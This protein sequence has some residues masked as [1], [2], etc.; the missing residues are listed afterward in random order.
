MIN[1]LKKLK[2]NARKVIYQFYPLLACKQRYYWTYGEKI[3]LDNPR[4]VDEKNIWL[5][6]NR[7]KNDQRIIDLI[8]KAK[9]YEV[10]GKDEKARQYLNV[11][12]KVYDKA[13]D[14]EWDKLP[15]KFAVKCNH[16]CGMNIFITDKNSVDREA[17]VKKLDRWMKEKQLMEFGGVQYKTIKPKIV[18]ERFL[19][20][21]DGKPPVDYKL[22]CCNGH[23]EAVEVIVDR[24]ENYH[25]VLVDR[26]FKNLPF[27]KDSINDENVI[28]GLKPKKWPD[29]VEAA[30]YLSHKYPYVRVDLYDYEDRPL[31]GEMTFFPMDGVNGFFEM[32][33]QLKLGDKVDIHYGE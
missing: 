20:T 1:E 25:Y 26:N 19:E 15:D 27:G 23:V 8:D 5:M 14:I 22:Y 33:G 10:Y 9:L 29:F 21:P 7:Y 17:V 12:Y 32:E 31:I 24:F 30:E 2:Y 4:T 18:C 11:L 6:Y 16:G 28:D 13:S 3:N